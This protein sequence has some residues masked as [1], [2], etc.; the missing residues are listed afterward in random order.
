MHFMPDGSSA[1]VVAEK[2]NRLEVQR[3]DDGVAGSAACP[4]KCIG[5]NHADFSIDGQYAIFA[6]DFSGGGL[7]KIDLVDRKVINR[8]NS[9]ARRYP[10]HP[11]RSAS[12]FMSRILWRMLVHLDGDAFTEVGF[13]PTSVG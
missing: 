6:C 11:H 1:I 10:G 13:V 7:V 3:S 4:L 2:Y 9:R 12:C 8:C 5:I